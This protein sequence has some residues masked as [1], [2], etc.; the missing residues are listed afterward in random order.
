MAAKVK[1]SLLILIVLVLASVSL[2]CS[3]FYL[4]Q[5]ERANSASLQ[6]ALDEL[7]SLETLNEKKLAENQKAIDGLEEKLSGAKTQIASLND[8]LG[9]EKAAKTAALKQVDELKAIL[10]EQKKVKSDVED[11]L[12][13][14][15]DEAKKIKTELRDLENKK[16][17]LEKKITELEEKLKPGVELGTIVVNP[18]TGMPQ[19]SPAAAVTGTENMSEEKPMAASG[20]ASAS[21]QSPEG[22]V[23]VVNKDY[24]FAVI[25]LGSEDGVSIGNVFSIYHNN[26]YVGDVKVEK[27]HDSMAAAA[28]ATPELKDKVSEGDKIVLKAK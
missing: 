10:E 21:S 9:T 22:K 7:K 27:V 11:K 12:I 23:L 16:S 28:F 2:A 15:Q 3:G 25:N 17:S 20:A 13:K 6:K 26:K 1:P 19:T 24:N 4:L 5:K 8:D 14:A 18:E